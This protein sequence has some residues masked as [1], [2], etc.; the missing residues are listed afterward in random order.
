MS[1]EDAIRYFLNEKIDPEVNIQ[2]SFSSFNMAL[3]EIR[4]VTKRD[5]L[6]GQR[7]LSYENSSWLGAIGYMSLLD[8]IGACFKPKNAPSIVESRDFVS[9]LKYFSENLTEDEILALYALRCAFMHDFS[10]SNTH[11]NPKLSHIFVIRIG[12]I[13]KVVYLPTTPWDGNCE[14]RTD[15]NQTIVDLEKFGDIVE[16][17]CKK[18][19]KF[20]KNNDLEI[21][22]PGG[23]DELISRYTSSQKISISFSPSKS[24]KI[25]NVTVKK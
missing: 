5:K 24:T 14:N 9:A 20:A 13:E 21:I 7:N 15:E 10:L 18:I 23:A 6:T 3:Y 1:N 22:L 19:G 4:R 2:G 17:I 16:D 11:L 12:G 8:M 25:S